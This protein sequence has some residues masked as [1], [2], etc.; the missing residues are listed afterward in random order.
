MQLRSMNAQLPLHQSVPIGQIAVLPAWKKT[1]PRPRGQQWRQHG[2]RPRKSRTDR[3]LDQLRH[4]VQIALVEEMSEDLIFTLE[5]CAYRRQDRR[6]PGLAS[7][8]VAL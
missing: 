1:E 8:E 4:S 3:D 2:C 7:S 5:I 6:D